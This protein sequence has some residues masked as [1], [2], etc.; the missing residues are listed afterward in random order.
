MD[1][2][3]S[4]S[5]VWL[6]P[7]CVLAGGLSWW[8]YRGTD[9]FV[10]PIPRAIL[11]VFRFVVFSLI[12]IL[13]L[14]PML[15]VQQELRFPPIIA[16][17]QDNT[18]SLLIQK[19]SNFVKNEYPNLLRAFESSFPEES[20]SLDMLSFDTKLESLPNVDSLTFNKTGTNIS[21]ALKNVRNRYQNQNLQ[22][23]VLATDG[24]NTSGVNPLYTVEGLNVPVY[25]VLV[26]DTT[27]Q[28]DVLIKEVLYNEIA[29]LNNEMP[30]QVKVQSEG[31]DQAPLKVSLRNNGKVLGT[32]N[33]LL[34]HNR[35]Q[36]EVQFLVKPEEAGLQQYEVILTR[37]NQ[38]ITYRNNYRRIYVN[39]LETRIKI[40]MFA[41]SPHP[42][43]GALRKAFERE[44][45]YE[46]KEF[47]LKKTGTYYQDPNQENLKDFDLFILHNYPQS[48]ADQAMIAKIVEEVKEENKPIMYFVGAF[49]DLRTMGPLFEYMAISPQSFSPKSEEVIADFSAS[50]ANHSTFTFGDNW[51][52]WANSAPPI[53]RNNS[54]W[55]A[56]STAEIFATAKIKN[57]RLDYPVYGLQNHL[58]RKNMV[59]LGENFWR[60]R[61][62]SYMESGDF[63]NFDA[64][65]FNNIKWLIVSDDK[66]KFKVTP[67][68][69]VFSGSDPVTFTGQAY[70]DSYNPI[71]GVDIKLTL[72]SP[73]KKEND[74][75]LAETGEAQYFLELKNLPE[76]TYAYVATGRKNE[77]TIGEDKG[78]FSI[79][80]SNIEH[81]QLQADRD[82]L[83]QMALR[84]SGQFLYARDLSALAE[85]LKSVPS[86]KPQTDTK[87]SRTPF[88]Q[89]EWVLILL[90][91]LLCAEWVTRKLFSLR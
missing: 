13:L 49:S 33:L 47:I 26:G 87:K 81:F 31:F 8:M 7:I 22:A 5:L 40:A 46:I 54:N 39:V 50:Y 86:M 51:L 79:G 34:G 36:G 27:P 28:K 68:K 60:M 77:A 3:F 20:Y 1:L 66:R 85:D 2:T 45:S 12:A 62:H 18:E 88:H 61:A 67:G 17:V 52:Q 78:Q 41:G 57:I 80:K 91:L 72:I 43:L 56:K 29:Y 11:A 71:S 58:G 63:E 84:T 48:S 69:R 70:D 10:A 9:E 32:Q 38:E 21:Q 16:F 37:L 4:N 76:G 6:I 75:F 35:A 30:I 59:F 82:L 53:F 42:D 73:D 89:F 15:V 14:Q 44:D 74:Y 23:I 83:Q 55:V 19:D 90:L 25:T 65:L 24:I 64:W